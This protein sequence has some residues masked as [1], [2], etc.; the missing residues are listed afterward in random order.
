M[1][2]K[3]FIF[4]LSNLFRDCVLKQKAFWRKEVFHIALWGN[5]PSYGQD[6]EV[7]L[8]SQECTIYKRWSLKIQFVIFAVYQKNKLL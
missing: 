7:H 2:R 3:E 5:F 8:M 1:Q 6:T 4:C